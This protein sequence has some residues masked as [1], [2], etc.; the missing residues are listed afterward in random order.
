MKV[1][2]KNKLR[3]ADKYCISSQFYF[4][5]ATYT[6]TIVLVIVGIATIIN[7][8]YNPFK[9]IFIFVIALF[10]IIIIKLG[11]S[12][13]KF[14]MV[15]FNLWDCKAFNKEDEFGNRMKVDETLVD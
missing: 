14:V 15:R 1:R 7:N 9:D 4:V 5:L 10:W 2:L 12:F 11:T 3:G 6:G 8:L 13:L